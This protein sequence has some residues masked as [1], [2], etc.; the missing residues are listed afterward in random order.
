MSTFNAPAN[1]RLGKL[2]MYNLSAG[3]FMV[4]V[5]TLW[6]V[7]T[8]KK[9]GFIPVMSSVV[10]DSP[11]RVT[12]GSLVLMWKEMELLRQGPVPK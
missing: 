9:S 12:T 2:D 6:H 8:K 5:L 3:V 10:L 1:N 4:S 11:G 7:C